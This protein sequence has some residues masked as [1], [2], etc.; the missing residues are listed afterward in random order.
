MAK[1][2][3]QIRNALERQFG[4]D[5]AELIEQLKKIALGKRIEVETEIPGVVRLL[6]P[7]ISEMR[8]ACL[9]LLAYQHGRPRQSVEV[10]HVDDRQRWNPDRLSVEELEQ[11]ERITKKAQ[12]PEGQIIEGEFTQTGKT[13]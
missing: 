1:P 2:R 10:E 7:T 5:S 9:D 3:L 11:F 4:P 12:L 8:E 6:S 13:Q